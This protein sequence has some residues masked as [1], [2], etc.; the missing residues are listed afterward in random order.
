VPVFLAELNGEVVDEADGEPVVEVV[1]REYTSFVVRLVAFGT[2][3]R[4]LGPPELQQ[5][6][7]DWLAPQAEAG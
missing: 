3:V 1:V 7:H 4:L 6:L 5:R 2:T